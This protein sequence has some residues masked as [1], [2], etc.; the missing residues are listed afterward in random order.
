MLSKLRRAKNSG[1]YKSLS[2]G[3]LSMTSTPSND[4]T[5]PKSA[6]K[7]LRAKHP[8]ITTRIALHE[9]IHFRDRGIATRKAPRTCAELP[10]DGT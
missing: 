8:D 2:H 1:L 6:D 7:S 4:N 3:L 5:P 9:Q 10:N